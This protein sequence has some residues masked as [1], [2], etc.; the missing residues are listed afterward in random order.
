MITSAAVQ[1]PKAAVSL[2]DRYPNDVNDRVVQNFVWHSF[3]N[4]PA[5]AVTAIARIGDEK[6]RDQMYRRT[7]DAWKREDPAS[8]EAWLSKNSTSSG[9]LAPR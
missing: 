1:N 2:M 8:A 4:D 3:G 6:Q 7:L 5:T 9:V